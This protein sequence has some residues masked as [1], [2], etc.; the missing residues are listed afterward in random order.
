M[1]NLFN[2]FL[3]IYAKKKYNVILD[4]TQPQIG[5]GLLRALST[6]ETVVRKHRMGYTLELNETTAKTLRKYPEILC[7]EEDKEMRMTD[8]YITES[9]QILN[10]MPSHH[11]DALNTNTFNATFILQLNSPWGL[12]RIAG[13]IEGYEY[14]KG[15]GKHVTVYILDTGIDEKH[16][17]FEGRA[18]M[19][20]NAVIGS[21]P[22][23]E[24]GHGTHCAGIIGSRTFGVAKEVSL[25]GVKVLDKEGIGDVSRLIAGI[26]FVVNDYYGQEGTNF[27]KRKD[28][29]IKGS[30]AIISISIGGEKSDALNHVIRIASD[31]F[32]IHF[33]TAA[34][35]EHSDACDYSPSSASGTLTI[36]ASNSL[37]LIA[38]FSN[39]GN[40]VD[41][42]APGVSIKSTWPK[43]QTRVASGTSMATPH[44]AGVMA[45]YLSLA[46]FTPEE[47]KKRIKLDAERAIGGGFFE[48]KKPLVSLKRMYERIK[49]AGYG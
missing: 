41:L 21:P 43:N 24:Q 35:N 48:M 38:P 40:C 16:H 1:L 27:K 10:F 12:N 26:D 7:V 17:E 29:S 45:V 15:G 49:M 25:V 14:I 18:S 20:F 23:D 8:F 42:F 47:L 22:V 6:D 5:D 30:D 19:K 46:D 4:P 34:G 44:V 28:G 33:A 13:Q 32:G 31:H 11:N 36:G 37:D 39:R 3:L 9:N 2:A